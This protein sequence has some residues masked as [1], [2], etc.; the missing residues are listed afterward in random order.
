[1]KVT[2]VSIFVLVLLQLG[3]IGCSQKSRT[4]KNLYPDRVEANQTIY[5]Y[6]N[7]EMYISVFT[8]EEPG[9]VRQVKSKQLVI[10]VTHSDSTMVRGVTGLVYDASTDTYIANKNSD[11]TIQLDYANIK[12]I[13]I[14]AHKTKVGSYDEWFEVLRFWPLLL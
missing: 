12:T 3:N 7:R 2:S 10:L 4:F 13:K 6:L 8:E 14:W 1:M 5:L 9:E 11:Q